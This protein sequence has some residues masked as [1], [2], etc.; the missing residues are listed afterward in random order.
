MRVEVSMQPNRGDTNWSKPVN[1]LHE[2]HL[3]SWIKPLYSLA[4]SLSSLDEAT[5]DSPH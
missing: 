5:E 1:C 2:K 4:A 3:H